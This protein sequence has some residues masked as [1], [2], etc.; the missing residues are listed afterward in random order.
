ML[1]ELIYDNFVLVDRIVS[2]Y[3]AKEDH[4]RLKLHSL[5]ASNF[6]KVQYPLHCIKEDDQVCT[7]GLMYSLGG[8]KRDRKDDNRM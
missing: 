5:I 4:N 7:H 1:D 6:L 8:P 2:E 3:T